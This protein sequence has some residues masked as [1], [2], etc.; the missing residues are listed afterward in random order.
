MSEYLI[1]RIPNN[2][3]ITLHLNP[4]ITEFEGDVQQAA[5]SLRNYETAKQPKSDLRF[6]VRIGAYPLPRTGAR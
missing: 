1:F 3:Q 4:A 5:V 2:R 6:F